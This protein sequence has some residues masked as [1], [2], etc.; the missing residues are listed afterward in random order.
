MKDRRYVKPPPGVFFTY[1]GLSGFISFAEGAGNPREM[2]SNALG[3][4]GGSGTPAQW[5]RGEESG[6]SAMGFTGSATSLASNVNFGTAVPGWQD[7]GV[8]GA[9]GSLIAR[10]F[11][12]GTTPA[13]TGIAERN[14]GNT[15]NAGWELGIDGTGAFGIN[16]VRA[17][18]N[19]ESRTSPVPPSNKWITLVA[20]W[21]T[22]ELATGISLY[23]DGILQTPAASGVANGVGASGTDASRSLII[24]NCS[25]A[26]SL[27][28]PK[29]S[30]G[31]SIS[32]IAAFRRKLSAAEVQE[33]SC[34]NAQPWTKFG[35]RSVRHV[36]PPNTSGVGAADGSSTATAVSIAAGQGV[37][38]SAGVG[39]AAGVGASLAA[40]VGSAAGVGA[41]AATSVT[42]D[43]GV[44]SAAGVGAADGVG[45]SLAAAVG[46]AAGVGAATAVGHGVIV[47]DGVGSSAGVGTATGV[48]R[49]LGPGRVSQAAIEYADGQGADAR[50]TAHAVE[51][52]DGQ[53]ADARVTA[54]AVE[55]ANGAPADSRVTAFVVEIAYR[56]TSISPVTP[57]FPGWGTCPPEDASVVAGRGDG[58]EAGFDWECGDLPPSAN[59]E[60][61]HGD[62]K[63]SDDLPFKWGNC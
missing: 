63:S 24:G 37:G 29:G 55:V 12:T 34:G 43:Q 61:G 54:H 25:Y 27:F 38:S 21:D 20:T 28:N 40:A 44:G 47:R 42:A 3:T 35:T 51:Y 10:V 59:P 22:T 8:T 16:F 58:Q 1:P 39:A 14:D 56:T 7:L 15:V 33:W 30:F 5:A 4:R 26:G 18:T 9:A 41:A 48:G 31:G 60:A 36:V 6:G 53:G 32:W 50:V 57:P 19:K 23:F 49:S 13:S 45:A 46:S 62:G 11:W 52:S 17:T 2:F